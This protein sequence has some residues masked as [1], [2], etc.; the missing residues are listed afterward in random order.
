MNFLEQ[1]AESRIQAAMAR[2][3]FADLPGMGRPLPLDDDSSIPSE[4]RMAFK[5]LKNSG[6]VPPEVALRRE[7][8]DLSRLMATATEQMQRSRGQ[9]RLRA[10]LLRLNELHRAAD[11]RL[12]AH[13]VEALCRRFSGMK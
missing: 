4:L 9:R 6:F 1:I 5:I 2:G 10:L 11:I 7:L 3:E 13:Y 12:E 8:W